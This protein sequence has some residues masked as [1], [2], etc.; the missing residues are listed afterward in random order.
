MGLVID[1]VIGDALLHNHIK[2]VS[3]DPSIGKDGDIII[4]IDSDQM[5]IYYGGT[6]QTLHNL[7]PPA[8]YFLKLESG[9][10]FLLENGD[11]LIL[12]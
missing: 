7:V 5:K 9:D 10:F 3:V 12:G 2:L 8:D 1:K 6:W 11:K 4:N